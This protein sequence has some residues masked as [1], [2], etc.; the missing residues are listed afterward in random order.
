MRLIAT[1][2]TLLLTLSAIAQNPTYSSGNL[3]ISEFRTPPLESRPGVYWYFMDGNF[4]KEG[5]TKDLESM[6]DAGIGYVV[7]L[8]VNVGVPR[9]NVDFMSE[10]WMDIF[11]HT[12]NECKRLDIKMIL[13]IGPGWTGSGGPWVKGEE[14]MQHLMSSSTTVTGGTRVSLDLEKPAPHDPYF[15]HAGYTEKMMHDWQEYYRDVAV[16]AFPA[17]QKARIKDIDEKALFIRAPFSS[18]EGVK[19]FLPETSRARGSATGGIR[20]KDMIDL[21]S[22]MDADGHLE[23]DAP[24]GEWTIMRFGSRNNGAVTRPAPV[25]GIGME[26]D[27]FSKEALE[28][29]LSNFTGKLL[30]LV[31]DRGDCFGGISY[32]HMDSWEMGAQNWNADF[33]K[34]FRKRR[35]YDPMPFY[36][37]YSGLVVESEEISERFLWD[38]RLTA[39]EL[40]I[41]N[42]SGAVRKYAHDHG[43]ELSIEPYDMNPTAD[44]ELA[45][46]ADVPMAEFWSDGYGFN[47]AFAAVEGTS[48]AHLIGQGTV[49]AESFTSQFDGWRQYPGSIKAQTDWALAQGINRLIFHTF[50]HQCLPDSLRPGMT[51]GPYGVHWDRGQTWWTM[52]TAY[53]DYVTRSQYMLQLGRNSADILY[54]CPE[55]APHVFKAPASAFVNPGTVQQDRREYNFDGCPPSMLYKADASADGSITFPSGASYR[56][57][58]LPEYETMT[59]QLLRKIYQLIRKGATVV[60]NPPVASPSLQNYPVCDRKLAKTAVKIWGTHGESIREIGKGRIIRDCSAADNLYQ[61]YDATTAILAEMGLAPD[62]V[63]SSGK[64]RHT[65]RI[66]PDGGDLYFVA[67]RDLQPHECTMAFRASGKQPEIWDPKDGKVYRVSGYSDNGVTTEFSAH[68]A[69]NGAFFVVFPAT[70]T[71]EAAELPDDS[72]RTLVT[73]IIN[74]WTVSFDPE[75]SEAG[76]VTFAEL[77]DWTE[78]SDPQIRYYSGTAGY[79][80]AFS[81]PALDKDRSYILNLGEVHDLAEVTLNGVRLGILWTSPWELDV[82]GILREGE[83]KLEIK[84]VNQ[85]HNRLI[86]DAALEDDGPVG[87]QWPDWMKEGRPRTSGR[88]TF[89]TWKHYSADTPLMPSGLKGP[90]R[91]LTY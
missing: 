82:T 32:L 87:G 68:F 61:R 45:V 48:A 58:V 81:A 8:E 9:G 66:L 3:S 51:M 91:I 14:S 85:W 75:W 18:R 44:L 31:G 52:S 29:H 43:M 60:G 55:G 70:P 73:E 65:H 27:K 56:I 26:C 72:I 42:H 41:A 53:H 16:L 54:L 69:G 71:E 13:G 64:I 62:F 76:T 59:P 88:Y 5:I 20:P 77:K 50:Q 34:E 11:K 1:I 24:D 89:A 23:W 12:V 74:P 15:G 49:P 46:S 36:P 21:S 37:V 38:V 83:N 79:S 6:R 90:V 19:Q 67:S 17:G 4:S 2:A 86:G 47:T 39:Q 7:F 28:S 33:R 80:T 57:L 30:D 22:K 10:E 63:A 78:C 35:G 84:V 25:P 40:V